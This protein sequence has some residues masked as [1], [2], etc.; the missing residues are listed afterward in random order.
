MK[1]VICGAG[2]IG[3]NLTSY[4][5]REDNDITVIDSDP[6][7][8]AK[9]NDTLDANGIV[10][11]PSHPN[12]LQDAGIADADMIIAVTEVD[13]VN[14]VACQV[15]HSLFGVPKKIARIR[16]TNFLDPSWS[17]LF[18][19]AH[20]PIDVII[21]PETETAEAVLRRVKVPGTSDIIPLIGGKMFLVGVH[22][23]YNCPIVNTPLRQLRSLFPDLKAQILAIIRGKERLIVDQDNQMLVGDEVY[24]LVHEDQLYRSLSVFG[25]EEPEARHIIIFGGG[26]IGLALANRI[27]KEI[28]GT[29]V[30]I[31]EL[32]E[33]RARELSAQLEG[34]MVLQG[35]GLSKDVLEEANV[36]NT[37]TF[38][39]VS[40]D[41]ESN[42]LASLLAKQYGCQ[43]TMAL[44]NKHMYTDLTS[45]L[46]IDAVISPR[47]ITVSKMLQY[48]RRGRI[49]GVH[50]IHDD[51][52]E[53][54]E[55]EVSASSS[56][57]N[58]SLKDLKLPGTVRIGAVW[59]DE[60]MI[61]PTGDLIIQ[62]KDVVVLISCQ[63]Y[64]RKVEKLFSVEIDLFDL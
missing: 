42:I 56:I 44:I 18:A 7:L 55:A 26:N 49:K 53:V 62:E 20:M 28:K 24:Y 5:S 60:D 16:S 12:V 3:Y 46:G 34:V 11:F 59:R 6:A 19:R 36:A 45:F 54:I 30:K 22:C 57:V 48:I 14:M 47:T 43:R 15:A 13:E 50:N 4:L 33:T 29:D 17:N 41:D 58:K 32:S 31:I 40:N 37:E 23:E 1:V 51:F 25:H 63:E 52:A 35:D 9:V 2:Q 61:I 27:H 38:I 64:A 10:G 8:V 39:A 21:S